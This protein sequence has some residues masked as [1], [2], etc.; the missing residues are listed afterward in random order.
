MHTILTKLFVLLMCSAVFSQSQAAWDVTI[1]TSG[2]STG[3]AWVANTWTPSATGSTVLASEITT[4]LTTGAAIID[5]T[6][7]GTENGDIIVNGAVN[8]TANSLTLNAQS[9]ININASVNCSGTASFALQYGQGA[10]AAGNTN[11][12]IIKT[13]VAVNLPAGQN[14]STKLG[15]DG[16]VINYTVI[17]DL[18]LAG[19]TTAMDLQGINGGLSANYALG[20]NIDATVTNT[21]NAGAGFTPIGNTSI[22]TPTAN[23]TGMFDGL[24][25]TISNLTINRPNTDIVGLFGT[26]SGTVIKNVGLIGGSVIANSVSGGGLAGMLVGAN[27]GSINNSYATGNVT[28]NQTAG[29]LIGY[30]GGP[31]NNSYASGNVTGGPL[32]SAGNVGGLV[33]A[34]AGLAVISNSYAT[35]NVIGGYT[36]GGL[37]GAPMANITNSYANG[38]VSGN[39][40]GAVSGSLRVGGL[41]G[42][43]NAPNVT[44][45]HSYATGTAS[46]MGWVGGLVGV[47]VAGN[48]INCHT[49][50]NV[51]G[52]YD[53]GGLVGRNYN[54]LVISGSY[55]SG[56]VT[57]SGPAGGL[58]GNSYG[59]TS[60]TSISNSYFAGKV[61][62]YG[63]LGGLLGTFSGGNVNINDAY[64]TGSIAAGSGS[65]INT[66]GG[67]VGGSQGG[68]SL[69]ISNAYA[70]GN[71]TT[72]GNVTAGTVGG[73][74]GVSG[75][76]NTISNAFWDIQATGQ[77]TSAA[78]TG[79]LTSQMQQQGNYTGFDF[80]NKWKINNGSYPVLT[81]LPFQ[82]VSFGS[83]PTIIIGQ[84]G[85]VSAT[86]T[87]ALAVSFSSITTSICTVSGSTVSGIATGACIIAANQ[88][89]NS[90]YNAAT[91]AMQ[92]I[93]IGA[94]SQTI[95]FGAV[96]VI[97]FGG[98]GSVS[99]TG[100]ASGIPARL[101]VF[102]P[103]VAIRLLVWQQVS[104]L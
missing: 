21:W 15:S 20:A 81:S 72:A 90:N 65:F 4:H 76:T 83:A 63:Y 64:T 32:A 33:G 101:Q 1:V 11:D 6:G 51:I 53:T 19:S 82:T 67:L 9:N 103:S 30:S 12:Y 44:I 17:T 45:T 55:A 50:N 66:I 42:E 92:N 95:S 89:G 2:S 47:V 85:T 74:V 23:F 38:S 18:G 78:G 70:A 57:G 52:G 98:T 10:V 87:S 41:V 86:A 69:T 40:I 43:I 61:N 39:L 56:V 80:A 94:L 24:G 46:G 104:V 28:H 31:I 5:T 75:T 16:I 100:G 25:H 84:V 22:S 79:L 49:T 48:I 35:G 59:L 71:I 7:S 58:V 68:G 34:T 13:A 73:L 88:A 91:Q 99:A 60:N 29:G 14:F 37:V 102:V 54:S 77:A 3:G 8:W 93:T 36:T 62:G 97:I 26:Y 96:S 27:S